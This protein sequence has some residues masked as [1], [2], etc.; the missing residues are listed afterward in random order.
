MA[1]KMSS[2]LHPANHNHTVKRVVAAICALSGLAATAWAA[3]SAVTVEWSSSK[4]ASA[5]LADSPSF[6]PSL[7]LRSAM[8]DAVSVLPAS[9]PS[10]GYY[11]GGIA[12]ALSCPSAPASPAPAGYHGIYYDPEVYTSDS[13]Y[14]SGT[15]EYIMVGVYPAT[16]AAKVAV[17]DLVLPTD[18]PSVVV[19]HSYA[20]AQ[21]SDASNC[22]SA[23]RKINNSGG[24]QGTNWFQTSRPEVV[25]AIGS[26]TS[27]Y[28]YVATAGHSASAFQKVGSDFTDGSDTISRYVGVNGNTS[29]AVHRRPTA[30]G[31]GTIAVSDQAGTTSTFFDHGWYPSGG[32]ATNK[33]NGQLWRVTAS[34]GQGT[35]LYAGSSSSA[36]TAA[37]SFHASGGPTVVVDGSEREWTYS[38]TT[39]GSIDRIASVKAEVVSGA[40]RTEVARV[41]Y[42]Y[43]G[44]GETYGNEGDLKTATTVTPVT[45]SSTT[46]TTV[47]KTHYYRYLKSGDGEGQLSIVIEPEGY[48]RLTLDSVNLATAT[49]ASLSQYAS[50]VY[51]EYDEMNRVLVMSAN[52][53][54]GCG[55]GSGSP[56]EVYTFAYFQ[57]GDFAL[58]N[59]SNGTYDCAGDWAPASGSALWY[60]ATTAVLPDGQRTILYYDEFNQPLGKVASTSAGTAFSTST[61]LVRV[62][63]MRRDSVG[64]IVEV[65]PPL[66]V[67][68]YAHINGGA[69]DGPEIVFKNDSTYAVQL[70]DYSTTLGLPF[71]LASQSTKIGSTTFVETEYGYAA[72]GSPSV[73]DDGGYRVIGPSPSGGAGLVLTRPVLDKMT[74]NTDHASNGTMTRSSETS[75]DY[76]FYSESGSPS[77]RTKSVVVTEPKVTTAQNGSNTSTTTESY[78]DQR[79]RTVFTKDQVGR[80][81]Y[82]E[83]N[84]YSQMEVRIDDPASSGG[85][86]A[87]A[88][89]FSVTLPSDGFEIETEYGYDLQGRTTLVT[90]PAPAL[91]GS[92]TRTSAMLYSKLSDGREVTI[93]IPRTSGYASS[94]GPARYSVTNHAGKPEFSATL[95]LGDPTSGTGSVTSD[96]RNWVNTTQSTVDP[97]TAVSS[98]GSGDLRALTHAAVSVYDPS[99]SR[100][101]ESWAFFAMPSTFAGATDGTHYDKTTVTY[102]AAGRRTHVTDPTGTISETVY[103]LFSRPVTQK[104]GVSGSMYEVAQTQYDGGASTGLAGNS[105]V[106]A[107]TSKVSSSSGDD[108]TWTYLH[109]ARNRVVVKLSPA[110]PHSVRK[111]DT[112]GRVIAAASYVNSSSPTVSTDPTASSDS[113]RRTLSESS[114]D[115]RGQVYASTLWEINQS[116]GAKAG[117]LTTDTWYN[118][119]GRMIKSRGSSLSKTQYDRLGRAVRRFVLAGDDDAGVYAAASS[120]TG[121]TVMEEA[122][123]YLDAKVG[124]VL[125][126]VRIARHFG[127]KTT[128]GALDTDSDLSLVDYSGSKIKG[129]AQITT[130]FYDDLDRPIAT[131]S[132][133]TNNLSNYDRDSAVS[134]VPTR[135][136]TILVNSSEFNGDGTLRRSIDPKGLIAETTYDAAR[137]KTKEVRN[138]VDGTPGN[139]GSDD[140]S[141][142]TV[143]YTYVDGL[144]T[145]MT[146]D[147]PTGTDQT[148]TYTYGVTTSVGSLLHSNRLLYS[149]QYPDSAGGSDLVKFGYNRLGQQIKVTDQSGNV[150]ETDYDLAGREAA[151]RATTI[152]SA[153]DSFVQRIEMAYTDRGQ[154]ATVTQRG[155]TSGSSTVRDQVAYDYDGWG[156]VSTF[157]QDV[158]SLIDGLNSQTGSGRDEFILTNTYELGGV[159][160]S[161]GAPYG[162]VPSMNR[163][164]TA[165][166]ADRTIANVYNGAI[167]DA[168]SRVSDVTVQ[169]GA[170]SAVPVATYGYLGTSQLVYTGMGQPDLTNTVVD[171]SGATPTYPGLDRFGRIIQNTWTR[172]TVI[173]TANVYDLE[174][175]YDENSN[176]TWT[177]DNVIKRTDN[178]KHYFDQL[179]TMDGLNRVT[180]NAQGEVDSS[181]SSPVINSGDKRR[182]ET[183]LYSQTGNWKERK[184][185]S[186]G[187]G[188]WSDSGDESETGS[189]NLANEISSRSITPGGGS[190]AT[191]SPVYDSVGNMTNDGKRFKYVYDVFGRLV[192]LKKR[193]DDSVIA[194]YK[195]NGLNFRTGFKYAPSIA[196]SQKMQYWHQYD[197]RW[198]PIATYRESDSSAKEAFVYQNAGIGG[199]GGSSYI[200]SVILRDR[201]NTTGNLLVSSGPPTMYVGHYFA[202]ASDGSLEQRHFYCQN[203]RAD[204]VVLTD[205]NGQPAEHV[206]YTAYGEARSYRNGDM[207][208]DGYITSTDYEAW[209]GVY[210][211]ETGYTFLPLDANFDGMTTLDDGEYLYSN[212]ENFPAGMDLG[213][214]GYVSHFNNR[215]GYAGYQFDYAAAYNGSDERGGMYHVRHRVYVPESGRWTRRDPLGYVDGMG[216]YEYVK[217]T[218]IRS[219][220]PDGR[221]AY[222][223]PGTPSRI[224]GC[225]VPIWGLPNL[226]T[227]I[228]AGKAEKQAWQ[229]AIDACMGVSPGNS[230]RIPPAHHA[231]DHVKKMFPAGCPIPPI[232]I[233]GCKG[234]GAAEFDPGSGVI[235]ICVENI[236]YGVTEVC[237]A[238][239]HELVHAMRNCATPITGSDDC[240]ARS[241]EE[242][243]AV[244]LSGQCCKGTPHR[245]EFDKK[246][247]NAGYAECVKWATRESL[248]IKPNGQPLC[249]ESPEF[250]GNYKAPSGAPPCS[251]I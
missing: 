125:S 138:Y 47:S 117:Y 82:T 156:N 166:Y 84:K 227:L 33:V 177:K 137:R 56:D 86:S 112:V 140:G 242:A 52:G 107:S 187:D 146:A 89:T 229:D 152:D 194:E 245:L 151:R 26:P 11:P 37:S 136:A 202:G 66:A 50:V 71:A 211:E 42:T 57:N 124:R 176:I 195:Y 21:A 145:S 191:V 27:D 170:G 74:R 119:A 13:G 148:T 155:G 209:N 243:A 232:Q 16:G 220:D 169:I 210:S 20:G 92:G 178:N 90:M 190:A 189:F 14:D 34:D 128:T 70:R 12:P 110:G 161:T 126:Q 103:D 235:R 150:I 208:L 180:E 231:V 196:S 113:N 234:G 94:K 183:W 199:R 206:R 108:R 143:L 48:R 163:K 154:V 174:L 111:Y 203:W 17:V 158:D 236:K 9:A 18:G 164:L 207:D 171:T 81:G 233:G 193:S 228:T 104:V 67:S 223:V 132:Y 7:L 5:E 249:S 73:M 29:V 102:D 4:V 182:A 147:L 144:M 217:N 122:Q 133:G 45:A 165:A 246:N 28:M 106:T 181:G 6:G 100:Q 41:D 75:Y 68:T 222:D 95:V 219:S 32:S 61:S 97:I 251:A 2:A 87:S 54:C 240:A 197:E 118:A 213:G 39:V 116:T 153:F 114:Y 31:G 173:G 167:E 250:E 76:V 168:L 204:V 62:S 65:Y 244:H 212:E 198:R 10:G 226:H 248:I 23:S 44:S 230:G 64:R 149:V 53:S 98:S 78:F 205:S 200:D 218:P 105:R 49:T 134:T 3:E 101:L 72:S 215:I 129:R 15:C 123:T 55:G 79:G 201:D 160:P 99:G 30:G 185:D 224:I 139:S 46:T 239:A 40:T 175:S 142:Q 19:G 135:S 216:L 77:W 221:G 159:N 91:G 25:F 172:T 24:P 63:A 188:D 141:D 83:Y 109:D 35:T 214:V 43:Y 127:D 58:T 184:I 238:I 93:S 36:S 69:T 1:R 51:K 247:P 120:V 131:A 186:N 121:D 162:D 115:D 96:Y 157:T 38:Y 22:N 8:E 80:F 225:L 237:Q 59:L 179:Y 130:M 60:R 192:T 85:A 241:A 88:S